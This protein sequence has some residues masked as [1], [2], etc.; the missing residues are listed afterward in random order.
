MKPRKKLGVLLLE[1]GLIDEEQLQ[2]A[3]DH[4]KHWG[5]R[6]G[7]ILV[8]LD[9]LSEHDLFRMLAKHL[10]LPIV[11]LGMRDVQPEALSMVDAEVATRYKLLPIGLKSTPTG[12]VLHVAMSDPTDMDALDQLQNLTGARI[13]PLITEPAGL[14]EAISKYYGAQQTGSAV[15]ANGTSDDTTPA[16]E[17]ADIPVVTGELLNTVPA[18][19]P[20]EAIEVPA[21]PAAAQESPSVSA[22]PTA[23]SAEMSTPGAGDTPALDSFGAMADPAAWEQS[24]ATPEVPPPACPACHTVLVAD[25][26]FCFQCGYNLSGDAANEATPHQNASEGGPSLSPAPFGA[27]SGPSPAPSA[28]F[29]DWSADAGEPAGAGFHDPFAPTPTVSVELSPADAADGVSSAPFADASENDSRAPSTEA[30]PLSWADALELPLPLAADA[31]ENPIESAEANADADIEDER[32]P[33]WAAIPRKAD[34]EAPHGE[35]SAQEEESLTRADI[36]ALSHEDLLSLCLRLYERDA[37][38]MEDMHA[39]RAK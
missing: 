4:Q 35:I 18:T 15:D 37:I 23:W 16:A 21:S 29:S 11:D 14:N 26:R 24:G 28:D 27:A 8:E 34:T 25:A 2:A 6:L 10:D 7:R 17:E 31:D 13:V 22:A 19:P 30:L 32:T 36:E 9:F 20:R 39:L 5:G 3:L 1:A 38:E 12:K 33:P